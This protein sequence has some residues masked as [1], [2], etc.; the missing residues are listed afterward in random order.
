M[1]IRPSLLKLPATRKALCCSARAFDFHRVR[2]IQLSQIRPYVDEVRVKSGKT[3][4]VSA[5][6]VATT[7]INSDISCIVHDDLPTKFYARLVK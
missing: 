1:E 5:I 6:G 7:R 3:Q 4:K 2:K